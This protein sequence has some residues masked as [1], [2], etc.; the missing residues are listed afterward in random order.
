MQK[1]IFLCIFFRN[2]SYT[3]T[4]FVFQHRMT[5]IRIWTVFSSA[6]CRGY[7]AK[8]FQGK[9][10]TTTMPDLHLCGV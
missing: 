3:A 5:H 8:H 2:Y 1:N 4:A 7:L 10:T 9:Y 6:Q